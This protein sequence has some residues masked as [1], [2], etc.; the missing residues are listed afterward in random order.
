LRLLAKKD[1]ILL[2][3]I[4]PPFAESGKW[5][6]PGGV[7]EDI[8][9]GPAREVFEETGAS[10]SIGKIR[11]NFTTENPDNDISIFDA[12]YIRGEIVAREEEILEAR[13]FTIPDALNLELAFNIREH[14][15]G[16]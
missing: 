15:T 3:R 6:F 9:A 14:I 1:K 2:V 11:D 5:N 10:F 8:R 12:A 7:I 4:A 13:W 16:L